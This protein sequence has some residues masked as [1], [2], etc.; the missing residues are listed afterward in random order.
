LLANLIDA[1]IPSIFAAM[2]FNMDSSLGALPCSV[3]YLLTA[4]F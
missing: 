2:L 1:K 4:G 3:A